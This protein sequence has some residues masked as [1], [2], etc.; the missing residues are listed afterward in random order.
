MFFFKLSISIGSTVIHL[1]IIFFVSFVLLFS[2][3]KFTLIPLVFILLLIF[4]QAI[5]ANGCV[6]SKLEQFSFIN[7]TNL[8]K[9][10]CFLE[11]N[12]ALGD[13]EKILIGIITLL[14]FFKVLIILILEEYGYY[15]IPVV[16]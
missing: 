3:N 7:L 16:F 10:G 13:I 11:K 14:S 2:T 4:L 9:K 12:I 5:I 6:I 1:I 15:R 8:V